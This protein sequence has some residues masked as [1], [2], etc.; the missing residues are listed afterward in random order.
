MAHTRL[1]GPFFLMYFSLASLFAILSVSF[2]NMTLNVLE[3][4][5]AILS[6]TLF[7]THP[8]LLCSKIIIATQRLFQKVG[9]LIMLPS[10]TPHFSQ[11]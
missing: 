2:V 8:R 1:S 9:N 6:I 3:N 11:I 7:Q 5:S 10:K 4:E